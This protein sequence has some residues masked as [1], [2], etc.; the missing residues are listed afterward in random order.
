MGIEPLD[1]RSDTV[2]RPTAAMRAAMAAAP[3]GDDVFGE[4]PCV[5]A[6]QQRLAA[7]FG[8]QAG[9]FFPS[10]T[11]ANQVA[12][13]VHA[14]PGTEVICDETAH[15]YLF[16]GGGTM[17]NSGCSVKLLRGDRGRFS[18]RD[19]VDAVN[20]P[21]NVHY[22]VSRLVVIENT[23]NRGGG[24]V[25]TLDRMA[26]V[27][28]ACQAHGLA[29]HLDGARIFNAL[30]V[31]GDSPGQVGPLFH[32]V[33]ICLSKGL[34]APVGSVLVGGTQFIAQA[35]RLR[36]RMGG[37]MRQAGMLAAAGLHALDHHL[38][39][40]PLDHARA[41][42]LAHALQGFRYTSKVLPAETNIVA[43]ELVKALPVG[44][45]L[46]KLAA[47]GVLTSPFGR[48]MVRFVTHSEIDDAA[49]EKVE[50]I[51]NTWTG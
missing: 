10:G 27:R 23:S 17:A 33:S 31:T 24:S 18:A 12:I 38:A 37:G 48:R 43:A 4:D 39:Q 19:V 6:L 40:L 49:I 42:R 5:N 3:V 2:T 47:M 13:G 9:L 26:D 46:G 41:A 16:E 36:K 35:K 20:D 1:F 44:A 29:L 7:L 25:W 50:H 30:A 8:H 28:A 32:S 14:G 51:L 21:E 34:G 15:V 22:P 11:M 45:F